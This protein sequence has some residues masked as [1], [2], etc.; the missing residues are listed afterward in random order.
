MPVVKKNHKYFLTKFKNA[1]KNQ[2]L[3]LF[4]YVKT[5]YFCI[6]LNKV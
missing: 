4:L 5:K 3:N 6:T 1:K 2:P